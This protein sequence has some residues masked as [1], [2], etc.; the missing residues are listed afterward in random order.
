LEQISSAFKA[1][2]QSDFD[3]DLCNFSELK[4]GINRALFT[5]ESTSEHAV[6]R[7]FRRGEGGEHVAPD[8]EA[9]DRENETVLLVFL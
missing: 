6:M 5:F 8:N 2:R 7:L 1:V 9:L 3:S 4:G